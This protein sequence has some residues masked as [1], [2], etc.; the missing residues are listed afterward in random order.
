MDAMLFHIHQSLL[1]VPIKDI[2]TNIDKDMQPESFLDA[3]NVEIFINLFL[4]FILILIYF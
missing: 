2:L 3:S 1:R 4:Y